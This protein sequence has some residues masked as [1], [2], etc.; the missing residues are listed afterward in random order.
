VERAALLPHHPSMQVEVAAAPQHG[1]DWATIDV[2]TPFKVAKQKLVDELDRRY[3][4]TL[5][6]LHDHNLSA[7]ARAA[8]LDRKSTYEMMRRLG[9]GADAPAADPDGPRVGYD[10]GNGK[11]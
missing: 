11:H 8:G 2:T 3:L 6:E 9:L 7:A 10:G 1:G 4:E 5:L